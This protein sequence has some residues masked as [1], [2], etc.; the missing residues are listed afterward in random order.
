MKNLI[1][2]LSI[3]ILILFTITPAYSKDNTKIE[4]KY[5]VNTSDNFK[6]EI[7]LFTPGEIVVWGKKTITIP[8]IEESGTTTVITQKDIKSHSDKTLDQTLQHIPGIIVEKHTKGNM[9]TKIRGFDQ[10]KIAIL[11]DGIPLSDIYS[12]DI[13]ISQI[14]VTNVSKIIITRGV[15]SA[16]YGTRGSAGL[17]NVISKKPSHKFTEINTEFG[18]PDN[19]SFNM[20]HGAPIGKFYYWLTGNL[21]YSGGYT[22]SKKLDQDKKKEWFDKFVQYKLYNNPLTS[23]PY[24]FDEVTFP[25]KDIYIND[26]GK[27]DHSDYLKTSFS[28]KA[29]YEFTDNFEMGTSFRFSYN[30]YNTSTFQFN[31]I[32]DY[33]LQDEEWKDPLFDVN[34][35]GDIKKV[36]LRNRAF[37]W[38]GMYNFTISPYLLYK[39]D[40]FIMKSNIFYSLKET[41]QI[42]YASTDHLYIKGAAAVIASTSAVYNPFYDIKTYSSYGFNIYP[43]YNFAD[44]NKLSGAISWRT[45]LYNNDQQAISAEESPQ[46]AA[47]HHGLSLYPVQ[48]GVAS[49]L[50]IAIE[51]E[52]LFFNDRLKF[53]AGVSYDSQLIHRFK[54]RESLYVYHD[55]YIAENDSMI[56]GTRDSINPVISIIA[57]PV[58]NILKIQTAGSIKTRFPLLGDYAKII[59]EEH[60]FNL[61]N[62]TAYSMNSGFQL[63]FLEKKLTFRTDYFVNQIK[64]RI[65]KVS[66]GEDPPINIEKVISQ[67]TESIITYK[68]NNI[69]NITDLKIS[70]SYIFNHVRNHDST[71]EE[72]VNKGKLLELTPVHQYST[73][74]RLDFN[75][76]T[77]I[78]FWGT[79]QFNQIMYAMTSAPEATDPYSTE[80]FE[81]VNVNNPVKLNL[82]ISQKFYTNYTIYIM[83]KNVLDDYNPNPFNPGSGREFYIGVNGKF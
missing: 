41:T 27:W 33:K 58:K 76:D 59:D 63:F 35:A 53:S 15:S 18:M 45:D 61:K 26:T 40:S 2:N 68:K 72:K 39:K 37:E 79:A 51:D 49:L 28:G 67:G 9:R 38:P 65:A 23:Q 29:G 81:A 44:W 1:T 55:I 21:F 77:S 75:S 60:D 22:P 71:H 20:A 50:T 46:I 69:L 48:Y 56:I 83:C 43:T 78:N 7:M 25:A 24:T 36:A 6:N 30:R 32:S 52:F 31:C 70:F 11:I 80:Y 54:Q 3:F 64:N 47:T 16:L 82:K 8:T 42:G 4:N 62:E 5:T 73:N 12:T 14:P 10:D 19:Y 34:T 74:L 17:I 13:D 57:E 66:G